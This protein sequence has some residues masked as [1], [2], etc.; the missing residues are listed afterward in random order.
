MRKLMLHLLVVF[1]TLLLGCTPTMDARPIDEPMDAMID[2][3]THNLHI[4]CI[5]SGSPAVIIDTGVTETYES[6]LPLMEDI[7]K[8][9]RVCGY[10]RAGYGQSEPGPLPRDSARAAAELHNLLTKARVDS[11]YILVGHSLGGLNLQVYASEYPEDLAGLVLLDP[12]PIGWI[13]GDQF[14]GLRQLFSEASNGYRAMAESSRTGSNP[15]GAAKADFF[16]MVAS[17]HEELMGESGALVKAISSF[18]AIP[19]TV[20]AATEA[21]PDFGEFAEP[22]QT[23]WIEQSRELA[24]K[25]SRGQFIKAEGSS[26][27]IHLDAPQLVLDAIS[28]MLL[29]VRE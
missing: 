29:E 2:I 20:I 22:F 27:H 5:G 24:G 28:E 15:E 14:P 7:A 23:F 11:P 19:L 21:N 4:Y 3:G 26:H 16:D 18:G 17:E 25:S 8:E 12:P 10:D 9:T 1:P 13:T 6:W